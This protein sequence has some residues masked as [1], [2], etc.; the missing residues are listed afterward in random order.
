MANPED[1]YP[2]NVPGKFYVDD[3]CIDC[4]LCRNRL[5]DIFARD[6]DGAHSYVSQQPKTPEE[7]EESFIAL[8]DCPVEAIGSDGAPAAVGGA[9]V[10]TASL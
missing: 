4:D 7:I 3:Q 10:D 2:Q 9:V 8:D 5:P 1:R 6:D